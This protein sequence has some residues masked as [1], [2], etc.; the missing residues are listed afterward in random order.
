MGLVAS[1]AQADEGMGKDGRVSR[2]HPL[3]GNRG[4]QWMGRRERLGHGLHLEFGRR[5]PGR[6]QWVAPKRAQALKTFKLLIRAA[7]CQRDLGHFTARPSLSLGEWLSLTIALL[8]RAQY[9]VELARRY[10]IYA[11]M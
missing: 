2:R 6:Q 4:V 10:S 3:S 1:V 11:V 9:V 7:S 5:G 8:F